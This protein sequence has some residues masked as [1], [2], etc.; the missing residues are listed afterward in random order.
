MTVWVTRAEPGASA[1]AAR[2][3]AR[4]REP[5]VAP[6]L[7]IAPLPFPALP[8]E[9][10]AL[11]FTS[12]N[13]VAALAGRPELARLR[14]L[15]AFAVGE[16]TAEAARAL[17]FTEV[18]SAGGDVAALSALIARRQ[19]GLGGPVLHPAARERAGELLGLDPPAQV[20]PVYQ[21]LELP[22][23]EAAASAWSR[24][25]AVLVHSP[26]AARA[27]ARAAAGRDLSRLTAVCISAAAAAPLAGGAWRGVRVAERPDEAALLARLGKP[28]R[29]G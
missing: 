9:V 18:V 2:L 24:L 3:V 8:T 5:L 7:A 11:A 26:R 10:G 16:A 15:P 14:S 28:P 20:V 25:D 29:P 13:G 17:G 1:T 19:A 12:R 4:G 23:P 22:L 27:L 6:L 21:A